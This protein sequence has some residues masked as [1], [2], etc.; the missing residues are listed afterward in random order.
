MRARYD[1]LHF[2][3]FDERLMSV[4]R[5]L[6]QILNC[7]GERLRIVRV[8][9]DYWYIS[10]GLNG[11]IWGFPNRGLFAAQTVATRTRRMR[12]LSL[13]RFGSV[14]DTLYSDFKLIEGEVTYTLRAVI[15]AG[16]KIARG[17]M[18]FRT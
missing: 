4:T 11:W 13:K 12:T 6:S 16:K 7:L 18:N 1:A 10:F 9:N 3:R 5:A 17:Q 15:E 2:D 8:R 14:F